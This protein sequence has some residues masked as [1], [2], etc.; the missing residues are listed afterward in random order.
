MTETKMPN[1]SEKQDERRP[2]QADGVALREELARLDEERRLLERQIA[3]A[4]QEIVRQ[5]L[6][7]AR[8]TKQLEEIEA[9][10]RRFSERYVEVQQENSDL[11]NLTVASQ[12]LHE[13]L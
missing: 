6:D 7:K 3:Q 2:T 10:Y 1:E 8:L 9:E 12:R 4:R 5:Q 13:S 11:T